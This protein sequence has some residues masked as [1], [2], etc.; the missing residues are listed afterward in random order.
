LDSERYPSAQFDGN[1]DGQTATRFTAHA[2]K[3]QPGDTLTLRG[4]PDLR[5]ELNTQQDTAPAAGAIDQTHRIRPDFREFA[6]V[7]Y[8]VIGPNSLTTPQ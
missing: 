3:L 6:P 1:L 5:S 2:I 8:I 4:I 7:D